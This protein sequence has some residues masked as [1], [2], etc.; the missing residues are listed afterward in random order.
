MLHCKRSYY[1]IGR[2]LL[3]VLFAFPFSSSVGA[4][5]LT[6]LEQKQAQAA[7][8]AQKYREL[9]DRQHDVAATYQ[10]KVIQTNRTIINVETKLQATTN[11]ISAYTRHIETTEQD[12]QVKEKTI[13]DLVAQQNETMVQLYVLGVPTTMELLATSGISSHDDSAE[14]LSA[15]ESELVQVIEEVNSAKSDLKTKKQKLADTKNH[16]YEL[17]GQQEAQRQ[18]LEYEKQQQSTLLGEAKA[19]ES[20]YDTLADEAEARK[21]E[22][23]R[24]IQAALRARTQFVSKGTVRRGDIIGYMGNTGYSTGPHLHF[25]V[26]TSNGTWVNPAGV[27]G[28]NGMSWPFDSFYVTQE[29]GRPNWNAAYEFHNG[30]DMVASAGYGA[31]VRAA[32]DGILVDP[33]PQ[34]NGFMANGYGR[35]KAVACSNGYLTLSGH[36]I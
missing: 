18:G 20:R 22:A 24:Q 14:Y 34:F 27:I 2:L 19:L 33:F 30:R 26:A 21:R 32:C 5:T 17:K 12:I 36:M 35:Y 23:D 15:I 31:P 8:D 4:A 9:E 13:H 16:L 11:D 10:D 7:N 28:S 6:D 29:F 25:S 1:W 3:I